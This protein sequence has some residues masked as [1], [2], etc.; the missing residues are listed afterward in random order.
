ME[1][2]IPFKYKLFKAQPA[3]CLSTLIIG[4]YIGYLTTFIWPLINYT[5]EYAYVYSLDNQRTLGITYLCISA[6]L[7]ILQM[8][9]LIKASVVNPGKIPEGWND[10]EEQK[11]YKAY[12]MYKGN[13][14]SQGLY[15]YKA[16]NIQYLIKEMEHDEG[17]K[18]ELKSRGFRLCKFCMQFKPPRTH[19]C[20]QC[21]KCVLKM[22]HHCNWLINCIGFFNYKYFIV[23]LF[24]ACLL[25]LFITITYSQCF[26]DV[27]VWDKNLSKV[28]YISFIFIMNV[29][30]VQIV[31]SFTFFHF[32]QLIGKGRTTIEFCE[33][34]KTGEYNL[35]FWENFKLTMGTNPLLW[36]LPFQSSKIGNGIDFLYK[37]EEVEYHESVTNDKTI[38]KCE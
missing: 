22:D 25:T 21:G 33:G 16:I 24:Y 15:R 1:F 30:V 9:S 32:T 7:V 18:I 28:L 26:Y 4:L 2:K 38:S 31:C 27:I 12:D 17:F 19:H 36:F 10:T 29:S 5:Y 6:T 3:I 37:K 11:A 14:T 23:G 8:Y 34:S 35:G 13:D 20:R